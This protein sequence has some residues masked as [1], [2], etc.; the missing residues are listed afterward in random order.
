[1]LPSCQ[2]S[3]GTHQV[4]SRT[5]TASSPSV[6]APTLIRLPE[7]LAAVAGRQCRGSDQA[8]TP[9]KQAV[10]SRMPPIVSDG[11]CQPAASVAQVAAAAQ[12]TPTR[13]IHGR[14]RAEET[15][16]RV[17]T[18]AVAI[19]ACPLGKVFKPRKMVSASCD[20]NSCRGNT[21][22]K[23][24]ASRIVPENVSTAV[25]PARSRFRHRPI[26][27]R[28]PSAKTI[29]PMRMLSRICLA[30]S[31]RCSPAVIRSSTAI[32]SHS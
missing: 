9:E 18:L 29:D 4:M 6:S 20:V 1:M 25:I 16:M 8:T 27:K 23:I 13:A 12:I 31:T 32:S 5:T 10:A 15:T 19:V 17:S 26:A 24:S 22:L 14:A 30:R 28:T 21:D 3:L 7:N 11:R 2:L